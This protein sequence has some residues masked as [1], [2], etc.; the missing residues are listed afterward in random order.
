MSQ[1]VALP[2]VLTNKSSSPMPLD[3]IEPAPASFQTP[4]RPGEIDSPKVNGMV[5]ETDMILP[6][7]LGEALD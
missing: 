1:H 5:F 2:E 4:V 3:F 7:C 6:T